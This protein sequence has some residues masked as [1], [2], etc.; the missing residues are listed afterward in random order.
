MRIRMQ[1]LF[2]LILLV[3][4]VA[5][6]SAQTPAMRARIDGMVGA[7]NATP[8]EFEK[9]AQQAY[10]PA[11]LER[12]TAENRKSFHQ[13]VRRDFGTITVQQ[14]ER[15]SESRV[16]VTIA[17]STGKRGAMML[18]HEVAEPH[19]VT[20]IR[21]EIEDDAPPV[22]VHGRMNAEEL[23]AALDPYLAELTKKDRFA[24]TVL[25]ARDGKPVF[26]K[27]YG[28]ADRSYGVPNMVQTRYNIGSINKHFTRIALAGLMSAGKLSPTDA[29]AKHIPDYPNPAGR[30]TTIQQLVDMQGGVADFF[31]PEFAREGKQRFR[32]NRDYYDWVAPKALL[33]A[34][35]SRKQYCNGCYIVLGEVVARISGMP[36]EKFVEEHVFRRGGLQTAAFLFSDAIVPNVATGYTNRETDLPLHSNVLMRG[37]GG[38]AAGGAYATARDLLALDEALRTG[39]MMDPERT[40]WFFGADEPFAGRAPMEQQYGGGAPGINAFVSA[41]GTWTVVV[42]ANLDPPAASDLSGAIYQALTK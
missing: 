33:F 25:V 24:G 36:Y 21:F 40:A 35:G 29:V 13:R 8:E 3:L 10:A 23:A 12:A 4:T 14:V 31:G 19:K 16:A 32:T 30:D 17:G 42:M 27:A 37:V 5:P 34:P 41:G 26:E 11:M 39:K 7:L 15:K 28:L 22:P 18:E 1:R 2:V 9:Y 20:G 38:S 6:L